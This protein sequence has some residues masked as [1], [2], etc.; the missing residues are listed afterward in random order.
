MYLWILLC[1][2]VY[3]FDDGDDDESDRLVIDEGR[4]PC[5]V[6]RQVRLEPVSDLAVNIAPDMFA[7]F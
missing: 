5:T 2:S 7:V 6:C 3:N 1:S 4:H